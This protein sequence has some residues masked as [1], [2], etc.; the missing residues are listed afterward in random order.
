MDSNFQ[1]RVQRYG[2]D[3]AAKVYDDLWQE[4]LSQTHRI[5][6]ELAELKS[7]DRIFEIACG[8]GFVTLKAASQIG[9]GGHVLA[10]DISAEMITLLKEQAADMSL[11]N[12]RAERVAAE[13]LEELADG[14]FD[15]ALCSLGLMF[16]PDPG[17]GTRGL[18]QALKPGGRAVATV[19]GQ[20]N[21]NAWAD[22]FPIVDNEVN[23][24]VCPLFFSLGVGDSLVQAFENQGFESVEIHRICV[25]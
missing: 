9:N 24:E 19:W 7:D 25:V 14:S 6:F 15:T 3:A 21:R 13:D 1:L 2:C 5:M 18:W 11:N 8:S 22:I 20:R 12:I 23:S 17:V 16:L 10:T 4:N